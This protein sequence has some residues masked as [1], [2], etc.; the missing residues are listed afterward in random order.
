MKNH[1]I[2]KKFLETF[3]A[4]YGLYIYDIKKH[5]KL[6]MMKNAATIAYQDDLYHFH[7]LNIDDKEIELNIKKIEDAGIKIIQEIV[8]SE[9][10]PNHKSL[11]MLLVYFLLQ[12]MRSPS[13]IELQSEIGSKITYGTNLDGR[14]LSIA[15][16]FDYHFY[17][18]EIVN[19]LSCYR[20]YLIKFD[21]PLFFITDNFCNFISVPTKEK[22]IPLNGH[23]A[24]YLVHK[25][26][27]DAKIVVKDSMLVQHL[28]EL[29]YFKILPLLFVGVN[30]WIYACYH[31][32]IQAI[33]PKL[34]D[35]F[36]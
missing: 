27:E 30:R 15:R 26:C 7:S 29:D 5:T 20:F 2:Q 33:I 31:P 14:D 25:E 6:P 1:F 8:N 34:C 32:T 4:D 11:Q 10:L 28:A 36:A 35:L 17:K 24:L 12:S 16:L 23:L 19:L 13:E 3:V 22:V 9:N 21:K 18:N